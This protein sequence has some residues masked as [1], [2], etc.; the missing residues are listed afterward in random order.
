MFCVAELIPT[1]SIISV[2]VTTA[3]YVDLVS[4]SGA[5]T[6]LKTPEEVIANSEPEILKVIADRSEAVTV[7]IVVWFS[8]AVKL[9][10]EVNTGAVVSS[11]V[12]VL[13]AVAVLP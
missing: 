8:S 4:K 13:V 2:A 6:K 7:P 9:D 11:T 3:V 1:K 5:V 10:D 12:T